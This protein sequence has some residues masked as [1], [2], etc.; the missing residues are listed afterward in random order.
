MIKLIQGE[1]ELND[2]LPFF[3]KRE[4]LN[5]KSKNYGWFLSDNFIIPFIIYKHQIFKRLVFSTEVIYLKESTIEEEKTFLNNIVR[6]IKKNKIC[7][8]IHKPQPSAVFNTYPDKA[9]PFRWGSYVME[10][11]PSF[12]NLLKKVKAN[13]RNY[14]RKAIRSGVIIEQSTDFEEIYTLANE[15]LL[16]QN[17]PLLICK[18]EFKKQFDSYHPKNMIMFKAMHENQLQGVLV[19]FY[20]KKNAFAEY[21]GSIPRPVNGSLKL[22]HLSA[23]EYLAKNLGIT[24]YDFIGA[25]PDIVEGTK[26]AGIQKFKKEFGSKLKEGYQFRVII[27]PVKYFLFDLCLKVSF[28]KKGIKYLDPVKRYKNLSK[29]KLKI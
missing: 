24:S 6:Y 2:D 26:E 27:N 10:I 1:I 22:L 18:N 29:S 5:S 9:D 23:M 15:T 3:A 17:I 11:E 8:F 25:I 13:Q 28:L 19:V 21:S 12:E 16:R 7:D 14:I 20:D 4:Y